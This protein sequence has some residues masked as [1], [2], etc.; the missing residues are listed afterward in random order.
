MYYQLI[1]KN[2]R[3]GFFYGTKTSDLINKNFWVNLAGGSRGADEAVVEKEKT[4]FDVILVNEGSNKIN[5][6]KEIRA[7]T[8]LPLKEAKR[9]QKDPMC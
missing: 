2:N 6:I 8:G 5:I 3:R 7:I 9:L 4:V 1:V